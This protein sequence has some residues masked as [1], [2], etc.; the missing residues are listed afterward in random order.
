MATAAPI[1]AAKVRANQADA[2]ALAPADLRATDQPSANLRTAAVVVFSSGAA[3]AASATVPL[4]MAVRPEGTATATA[5]GSAAADNGTTHLAMPHID[6]KTLSFA[7]P[8]LEVL[9]PVR[10][11]TRL[12]PVETVFLI[13]LPK[14]GGTNL[15]ALTVALAKMGKLKH[16]RFAVPRQKNVSPNRITAGWIG[17]LQTAKEKL[18]E[19]PNFCKDLNFITGHFPLG[20]HKLTGTGSAKYVFIMRDPISRELSCVNFAH[21][22]EYVSRADAEEYILNNL[23]N[24]Q[25]RMLAG[26]EHMSGD[27]TEKTLEAAKR[28]I[29]EHCLLGGVTEDTNAFIQILASIQDWGPVALCRSQVTGVKVF[30]QISI[31]LQKKLEEKHKFDLQLYA[32]VK[33]RWYDWKTQNLDSASVAAMDP[34]LKNVL[35]VDSDFVNTRT[36]V[37]RSLDEIAVY[38]QGM[39]DRLVQVQQVHMGLPPDPLSQASQ[40]QGN[41]KP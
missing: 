25:T 32:W 20:L 2:A 35:C 38:N 17:G 10:L 24:P 26:E 28:N 22:R 34:T 29:M 41:L 5:G 13:H 8:K 11:R 23:D 40:K 1:V 21:Q 16:H 19:E 4:T 36:P 31:E 18:R 14:T 7:Y 27:C 33:Q 3:G 37:F 9:L 6:K 12:E 30:D 39:P 15:D